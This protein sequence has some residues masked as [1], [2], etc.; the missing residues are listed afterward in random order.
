MTTAPARQRVSR[1]LRHAMLG[2]LLAAPLGL[3]PAEAQ[4]RKTAQEIAAH[5][6]EIGAM[7]GSF[8]QIDPNGRTTEGKFYIERP[9]KVRFDYTGTPLRVISDGDNVAINNRKLNTWDTYPLNKTPLKLLLGDRID[10]SSANIQSVQEDP[11][12]TTIVMG[13]KSVFGDSQITMMFDPSTYDL[14][15]WTI[16][17][18]QGKDTTVM[19]DKVRSGVRLDQTMFTIPYQAIAAGQTGNKKK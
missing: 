15:Q 9:G 3:Q 5:F 17:D 1:A 6:S 4:G 11:D 8:I 7:T 10:L 14:R 19:V 12:L 18:G 16:R 2:A 13:D